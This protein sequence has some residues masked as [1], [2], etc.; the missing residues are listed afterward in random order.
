MK[1]FLHGALSSRESTLSSR[2]DSS[3][4]QY[5]YIPKRA[6]THLRNYEIVQS[7]RFISETLTCP[8]PHAH[9][10]PS[11]HRYY[12]IRGAW[13]SFDRFKH[14]APRPMPLYEPPPSPFH[15]PRGSRIPRSPCSAIPPGHNRSVSRV[16]RCSLDG[17]SN[18]RTHSW[19]SLW[20]RDIRRKVSRRGYSCI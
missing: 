1:T 19:R 10:S 11:L 13:S 16:A 3:L 2:A 17:Q 18:L 12:P 9:R 14:L 6:Y 20:R 4:S 15:C 8:Y 5:T 7:I